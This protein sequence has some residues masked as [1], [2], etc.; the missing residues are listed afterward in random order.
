MSMFPIASAVNP[1]GTTINFSNIPQTFTHLQ[2]R[3]YMRTT[4]GATNENLFLRFN[5]AGYSFSGHGFVGTGASA[6][7]SNYTGVSFMDANAMATN[8]YTTGIFGCYIIDILDYTNTNKNKTVK[9][10][11][12]FDAN[13]SGSISLNSGLL[14]TNDA[15]TAINQI[16]GTATAGFVTG[17]RAD[18]YGISTSNA[19]GA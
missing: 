11:G 17:T 4:Y 6:V 12:G 9:F 8:A 5:N 3:I 15:I 16:A 18:L 10:L 2:L 1:A 7:G 14:P 13:G 19:T